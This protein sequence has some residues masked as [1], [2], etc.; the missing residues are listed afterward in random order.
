MVWLDWYMAW[1]GWR[2]NW[3]ACMDWRLWYCRPRRRPRPSLTNKI[4]QSLKNPNRIP[5]RMSR[6]TRRCAERR[7]LVYMAED[8][9]MLYRGGGHRER[10]ALGSL[11]AIW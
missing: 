6:V 3:L 1:L 9:W 11:V 10:Q 8:S 4:P 2:I 7:A 5:Q